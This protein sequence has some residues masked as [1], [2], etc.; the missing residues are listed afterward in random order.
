M[1]PETE[2]RNNERPWTAAQAADY[3]QVHQRTITRLAKIG[4]IPAF[5]I[6]SHWRFRP[7]DL[8]SWIRSKVECA[9]KLNPVRGS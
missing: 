3:L 4:E 2:L 5:R 9:S 8:D 1:N 7:A 6:G